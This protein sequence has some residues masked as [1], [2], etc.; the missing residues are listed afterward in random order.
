MESNSIT[1]KSEIERNSNFH[2]LLHVLYCSMGIKRTKPKSEIWNRKTWNRKFWFSQEEATCSTACVLMPH[3]NNS[4][5]LKSEKQKEFWFLLF[6]ACALLQ[7]GDQKC[8]TEN[9]NREPWNRKFR[10][11]QGE[12]TCFVACA[13]MLHGNNS[14]MLKSEIGRILISATCALLSHGDQKYKTKIKNQEPWNRKFRF[15]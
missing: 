13:L 11:S 12:A 10:F 2:I 6:A 7:H 9:G 1:L 3:G 4:A 15:P 14:A 5:M 8:K